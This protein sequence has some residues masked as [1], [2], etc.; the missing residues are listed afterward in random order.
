MQRGGSAGPCR[1]R[2]RLDPAACPTDVSVQLWMRSVVASTPAFEANVCDHNSLLPSEL[3]SSQGFTFRGN[4]IRKDGGLSLCSDCIVRCWL[5]MRDCKGV[6]LRYYD[7]STDRG[8]CTYYSSIDEVLRSTNGITAVA[9]SADLPSIPTPTPTLQPLST[10]APTLADTRTLLEVSAGGYLQVTDAASA[11]TLGGQAVD[12]TR[13]IYQFEADDDGNPSYVGSDWPYVVV[14][15]RVFAAPDVTAVV[16]TND[17]SVLLV[18]GKPAYQYLSDTGESCSGQGLG[19]VWFSFDASGAAIVSELTP[20]PTAAPTP[21]EN[22]PSPTAMP[23]PQEHWRPDP[24]GDAKPWSGDPMLFAAKDTKFGGTQIRTDGGVKL[25]AD[26]AARCY[27]Q[28][29]KACLGFTFTPYDNSDAGSCTYFSSLSGDERAIGVD[30]ITTS[31]FIPVPSPSSAPTP[32]P[33]TGEPTPNPTAIPTSAAPT[34]SPTQAPTPEP[35]LMPTTAGPTQTPTQD[36]TPTPSEAPTSEPTSTPTTAAPSA[37]PTLSPT[38]G[39]TSDAPTLTPTSEPTPVPS[40]VPTSDPTEAPQWFPDPC[41]GTKP[42]SGEPF[43][44]AA[45]SMDI[46]GG[47]IRTDGGVSLCADCAARCFLQMRGECVGFSF[48]PYTNS[49]RGLCTYFYSISGYESK[50]GTEAVTTSAYVP[51]SIVPSPAPTP[52]VVTPVPTIGPTSQWLS[53]PCGS[54][55][56]WSGDPQL[57]AKRD[58]RFVGVKMRSDGGVGMCVDCAARCYLQMQSE[59]VGFVFAPS[60]DFQ[61]VG[62]CTYFSSITGLEAASGTQAVTTSAHV[63]GS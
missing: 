1:L 44:F 41:D 32:S 19:G 52:A 3:V 46:V 15:A 20:S 30:A 57:L 51:V 34:T 27:L 8:E 6:S 47:E 42:W 38:S 16:S 21:H 17:F 60:D 39:P 11:Q 4:I 58:S 2:F 43:L 31:A 56:P 25:C 9:F 59:C 24:C 18:N 50:H 14:P 33:S 40:E 7:D 61:D 12:S 13:C 10:P 26:C 48:A 22:T 54:Q 53:N 63:P 29:P 35:T 23:T 28:M 5:Q 45:R 37:T 55:K 62:S 49:E 36:P